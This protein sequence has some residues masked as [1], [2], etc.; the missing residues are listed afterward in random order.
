MMAYLLPQCWVYSYPFLTRMRSR[1]KEGQER[2][3]SIILHVKVDNKEMKKTLF[4][5]K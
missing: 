5:D 4:P 2:Q 3:E 1:Q